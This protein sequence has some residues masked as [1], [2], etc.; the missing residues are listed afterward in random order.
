MSLC[1]SSI[2]RIKSSIYFLYKKDSERNTLATQIVVIRVAIDKLYY[3][4]FYNSLSKCSYSSALSPPPKRE[5]NI[6]IKRHRTR[7]RQC[8]PTSFRSPTLNRGDEGLREKKKERERTEGQGRV[9]CFR[10]YGRLTHCLRG[11]IFTPASSPSSC[12]PYPEHP[13]VPSRASFSSR[14]LPHHS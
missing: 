13:P 14:F 5:R 8:R 6:D 10:F 11:L 7:E 4:R 12:A 9:W 2:R 1:L 3:T